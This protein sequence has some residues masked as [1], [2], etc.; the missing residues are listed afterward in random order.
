M[1]TTFHARQGTLQVQAA[2]LRG[3]LSISDLA[4]IMAIP[5]RTQLYRKIAQLEK[6]GTLR[7]FSRGMYITPVFEPDALSQRLCERSYIS[8]GS[9]LAQHMLIGSV[10]RNQVDAVKIGPSRKYEAHGLR[11]RHFTCEAPAFFGFK[12][13]EGILRAEPEKAFLDTLYYHLHGVRFH[14]DIFSDV[15]LSRLS[16]SK[17]QTHLAKYRNPKFLSFVNGF[18]P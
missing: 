8:F 11:I 12:N 18:F 10:P 9:I 5:H 3:V 6:V 16:F 2:E 1:K 7:Q 4:I 13:E 15:D 14:F 17:L